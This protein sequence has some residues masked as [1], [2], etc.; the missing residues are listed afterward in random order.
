MSPGQICL[1]K[2]ALHALLGVA[3]VALMCKLAFPQTPRPILGSP[4]GS[5]DV[6]E[7]LLMPSLLLS[8]SLNPPSRR[9][10]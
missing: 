10:Y 2:T 1:V 5:L 9:Y 7:A 6:P 4:W 8:A 3:P